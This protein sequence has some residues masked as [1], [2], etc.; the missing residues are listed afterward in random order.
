MTHRTA[1]TGKTAPSK[2]LPFFLLAVFW[3]FPLSGQDASAP[4]NRSGVGSAG[5]GRPPAAAGTRSAEEPGIGFP[6]ANSAVRGEALSGSSIL[7]DRESG[8]PVKD[9]VIDAASPEFPASQA[10]ESPDPQARNGS[11]GERGGLVPFLQRHG[12]DSGT[13]QE[14]SPLAALPQSVPLLSSGAASTLNGGGAS[15]LRRSAGALAALWPLGAVLGLIG[16]CLAG[17]QRLGIVRRAGSG[18]GMQVVSRLALGPR[19]QAALL[20]LSPKRLLLVGIGPGS[21]ELLADLGDGSGGSTAGALVEGAKS[22]STSEGPSNGGHTAG[23]GG[24]HDEARKINGETPAWAAGALRNGFR[25]ILDSAL[26]KASRGPNGHS[27]GE[28]ERSIALQAGE[29]PTREVWGV[30]GSDRSG[31]GPAGAGDGARL[32][33]KRLLAR[34]QTRNER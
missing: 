24:G 14:N 5:D 32:E 19:H 28:A 17:A 31:Q 30:E 13:G 8:Q 7:A 18:P 3:V 22:G 11:T 34:L 25:R 15:V 16:L 1:N 20:Q 21:V 12:A 4:S 2:A 27:P 10:A 23:N 6:T 26:E 9:A 33:L 29:E